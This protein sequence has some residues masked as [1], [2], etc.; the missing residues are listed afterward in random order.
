M[1]RSTHPYDDE[2]AGEARVVM[3]GA[4]PSRVRGTMKAAGALLGV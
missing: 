1:I 4:S 2:R 3:V